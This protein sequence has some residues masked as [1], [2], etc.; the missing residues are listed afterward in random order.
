MQRKRRARRLNGRGEAT[1][2][3][4]RCC[5]DKRYLGVKTTSR[6]DRPQIRPF[7]ILSTIGQ[8]TTGA[9]CWPWADRSAASGRS[10]HATPHLSCLGTPWM[11]VSS[12][13]RGRE[14][15]SSSAGRHLRSGFGA[16]RS[17]LP[18]LSAAGSRKLTHSRLC[19]VS[20]RARRRE[21]PCPSRLTIQARP[22]FLPGVRLG[23]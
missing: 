10:A 19:K 5:A 8:R 21:T 16:F 6:P 15:A 2:T 14:H 23:S 18:A 11:L 22:R 9:L 12:V 3:I 4:S 7:R 13:C 17:L 1:M 20:A